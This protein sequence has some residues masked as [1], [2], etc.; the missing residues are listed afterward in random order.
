MSVEVPIVQSSVKIVAT[1]TILM[2]LGLVSTLAVFDRIAFVPPIAQSSISR[3]DTTGSYKEDLNSTIGSED[4]ARD[5][6]PA[7]AWLMTYPNSVSQKP[8]SPICRRS[9]APHS[10]IVSV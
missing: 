5:G 6:L 9:Q 8:P 4:I 10:L 1:G 3:V 2:I 7:I